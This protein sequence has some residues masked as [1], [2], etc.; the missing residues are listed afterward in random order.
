MATTEVCV[1]VKTGRAWRKPR[2]VDR[3]LLH[4]QIRSA[5]GDRPGRHV[6]GGANHGVRIRDQR[7]MIYG[8]RATT[9]A[10]SDS[11]AHANNRKSCPASDSQ[12]SPGSYRWRLIDAAGPLRRDPAVSFL[13]IGIDG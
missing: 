11:C 7:V 10:R 3:G 12:D 13:E 1:S 5:S 2:R 8:A 4:Q 9:N 6:L